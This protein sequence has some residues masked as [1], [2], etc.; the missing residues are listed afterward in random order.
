[1]KKLAILFL[2]FTLFTLSLTR[3][4]ADTLDD[5]NIVDI[6]NAQG[7]RWG[8]V[9]TKLAKRFEPS[10]NNVSKVT[11]KLAQNGT[12]EGQI[13][14]EIWSEV[15]SLPGTLLSTSV[16]QS[17][18]NVTEQWPDGQNVD[19]T[20]TNPVSVTPNYFYWIVFNGDYVMNKT[21]WIWLESSD[22]TGNWAGDSRT[23]DGSEWTYTDTHYWFE[24]FYS[25][26]T[27][28]PTPTETPTPA[29]TGTAEESPTPTPTPT[30]SPT[31]TPEPI[32]TQTII[33]VVTGM[34]NNLV[35][36]FGNVIFHSNVAFLAHIMFN[37]DTA[38]QVVVASGTTST[39]VTFENEYEFAPVIGLTLRSP[40]NLGWFRVANE[41]TTGFTV[42]ISQALPQDIILNWTAM[43]VKDR[44][45]IELTPTPSPTPTATPTSTPTPSPTPTS[46]PSP[47]LILGINSG[48]DSQGSL[49]AD[50]DYNGGQ[51]Y[52]SPATVDMSAVTNPAPQA[53]Y[54]SVRY[55]NFTYNIPGLT[56]SSNYTLRLHFNELYW[57]TSLAGG[58]GGTGSR[59]FSVSANGNQLLTSFDIYQ[60]AG[61]SNKAVVEEFPVTADSNGNVSISFSTVTDNAMVN[62]IELYH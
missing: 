38:G 54:Q 32:T 28:T 18:S 53:V 3:V 22:E 52:T 21:N 15:N 57:G 7:L 1:M 55:G 11:L 36:F 42:E 60:T 45:E 23:Y 26:A 35:E 12:P 31:A 56:P 9:F 51:L 25:S 4:K 8:T 16:K 61:G 6:D 48:G 50:T 34:F 47:T 19:F 43:S 2:T 37:K 62:G 10:H 41:S 5:S 27:P 59:V 17:A 58:A 46:T 39:N 33:D 40:V 29:P 14:V 30:P 44:T 49:V 20:F 13:W 24:E